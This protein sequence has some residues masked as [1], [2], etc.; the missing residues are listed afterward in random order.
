MKS[1]RIP[2]IIKPAISATGG[3]I[4]LNLLHIV[5]TRNRTKMQTCEILMLKYSIIK[6]YFLNGI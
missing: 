5:N 6:C 1:R 3:E 4:F 2:T